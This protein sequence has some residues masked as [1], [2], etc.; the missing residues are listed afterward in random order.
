MTDTVECTTDDRTCN[1][2]MRHQYKV[3]DENEK[4][5]MQTVKDTGLE[6]FRI[7]E[8]IETRRGPTRELSLAKTKI[9]EAVMWAVKHITG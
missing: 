6:F 1:N 9:E 2:V 5:D 7:I 3:L 4:I 8:T